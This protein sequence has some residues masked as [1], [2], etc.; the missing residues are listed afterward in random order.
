MKYYFKLN[1]VVRIGDWLHPVFPLLELEVEINGEEFEQD[2]VGYTDTFARS[3]AGEY[4][5]VAA[6]RLGVSNHLEERC[7]RLLQEPVIIHPTVQAQ[8][9]AE[10]DP[11]RAQ[12][13]TM[14]K[15]RPV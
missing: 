7:W 10:A 1:H 3:V 14:D 5:P 8:V 4:Q 2:D 15:L 9:I 12:A 11:S 13:S 6:E